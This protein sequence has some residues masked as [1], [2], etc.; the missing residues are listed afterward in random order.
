[1]N[2]K[3]GEDF[4]SSGSKGGNAV[5]SGLEK[6]KVEKMLMFYPHVAFRLIYKI[7]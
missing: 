7:F 6:D 1:M 3:L 5:L 2:I 4:V